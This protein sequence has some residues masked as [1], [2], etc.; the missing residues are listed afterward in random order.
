[1]EANLEA[2]EREAESTRK[3]SK[4]A[5]EAFNIIKKNRIE[6]FNAAYQHMSGCIDKI[7]KDLT[8][9]TTFPT[10]GVG[11]LSLMD[12]DVSPSKRDRT[13]K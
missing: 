9:S 12:A 6:K 13:D 8:K 4:D 3:D 10:G 11:F 5:K 2:A 1:M 7:Y